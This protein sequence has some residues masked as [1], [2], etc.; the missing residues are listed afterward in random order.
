MTA[1]I[2]MRR[3]SAA[4]WSTNTL[5]AGE[6]GV[7]IESN[8]VIGVKIGPNATP[9]AYNSLD[10]L[11]GTLPER[12]TA[13]LT[14]L[15]DN[16]LRKN[17]RYTFTNPVGLTNGPFTFASADGSMHLLTLTY[18]TALVQYLHTEGDGTIPSKFFNRTFD[19]GAS[20]FRAWT[21]LSNWA[22]DASTGTAITCTTL[23]A[24][25]V[26]TFSDGTASLP[27]IANNGDLDTGIAWTAD[28]TLVL[29]T[30]GNAAITIGSAQGVTLASNLVVGGSVQVGTTLDMTTGKILN[31]DTPTAANDAANKSYVDGTRIGQ[32]AIVTVDSTSIG[33]QVSGTST[34]GLFT[35]AS[36]G[37]G[38]LTSAIGTWHG[39]ACSS[40]GGFVK[41]V[42][43][44]GGTTVT[45]VNGG[46]APT[47]T[48]WATLI[49]IS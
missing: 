48:F 41:V 14:D 26:A 35:I 33:T 28:N 15:N 17:G 46:T 45:T 13:S 47:N 7:E 6:M 42:V 39:V 22:S 19:S 11:A 20:A 18:G 31:L 38:N 43:S 2:Q 4:N 30:N 3:D 44:T 27:S 24:K 21:P 29:A 8:V 40:T 16:A 37:I 1:K 12:S 32:T 9:Q 10:Y 23:D 25:G 5:A 36:A 34:S 49:R